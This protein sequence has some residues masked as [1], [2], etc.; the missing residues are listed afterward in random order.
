MLTQ[1]GMLAAPAGETP[2][3]SYTGIMEAASIIDNL[4]YTDI[5]TLD[6]YSKEAII[7][8]GALDVLKIPGSRQFRPQQAMTKQ[9]AIMMA[10]NAAG[11]EAEAQKAGEALNQARAQGNRKT[12]TIEVWADGYMQLALYD[13]LI[14]QQDYNNAISSGRTSTAQDTF[15]KNAA[16]TREEMAFWLA[17]A[18]KIEPV[19]GQQEIFN[20]YKDWK[21]SQPASVPYI[22]A[23]LAANIMYGSDGYFRPTGHV[24]REQGALIA[25]NAE[26]YILS[27]KNMVKK[28]GTIEDITSLKNYSSDSIDTGKVISIRNSDGSLHQIN[29]GLFQA[30]DANSAQISGTQ[31]IVVYRDGVAGSGSLLEKGDRIEYFVTS[32]NKTRFVNVVSNINST[33]YIAARITGMDE[34]LRKLS[35]TQFMQLDYPDIDLINSNTSLS[36]V[37]GSLQAVYSYSSIADVIEN[38]V[39]KDISSLGPDMTVILALNNSNI[40]T[41]IYISD[42]GENQDGYAIVSGIIEDVNPQLGYIAIYSNGKAYGQESNSKPVLKIYNYTNPNDLEIFRNHDI[43]SIEDLQ[44]G[45]TVFIKLDR[46]GEVVSASAADNYKSKYARVI[47]RNNS[48]LAVKYEDGTEQ[49]LN[50]GD[51]VAIIADGSPADISDIHD[52]DRIRLLVSSLGNSSKVIEITLEGD[53]H[54][55]SGIYKG[56]ITFVDAGLSQAAVANLEAYKD[57][58]WTRTTRKGITTVKIANGCEFYMGN[59]RL[60]MKR[61]GSKYKNAQAYIAV[62][63]DYGGKEQAVMISYRNTSDREVLYS[64]SVSYSIAGSG[65]FKIN[66]AGDSISYRN[67][68]IIIKNGRLV[69][70]SS[71]KDGDNAYVVANRDSDSGMFTAGIVQISDST[72]VNNFDIYRGRISAIS[73]NSGFT[74]E[75]F[76]RLSGLNWLYYNTP[77]TFEMTFNTRLLGDE[78]LIGQR[79]FV[80]YGDNSYKDRVVYVVAR[81]TEALLVSTA[82][83][84]S[85]NV[86]GQIYSLSGGMVGEEGTILEEPTEISIRNN[87][88][89]DMTQQLWTVAQDMTLTI[90]ANCVILKNGIE[91]KASE[92]EKGDIVR[93]IKKDSAAGGD[94]YIILVEGK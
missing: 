4:Q 47:S 68:S 86:R 50:I 22:E 15:N 31:D 3:A 29:T 69:T 41:A 30:P 33:K 58:K 17:K 20:S 34:S 83:Y 60:D 67:G 81:D 56:N 24:T 37:D 88:V 65:S 35:V 14:T 28:T 73:D 80:T 78:G 45:D 74:L 10:Y 7:E 54:L 40:V 8:A 79:D 36:P 1:P 49:I 92:L 76:S 89:F 91:I 53:E 21:A 44:P 94:A 48:R 43:A 87:T 26:A 6:A 25:K 64:D 11:R 63:K 90:P 12:D 46:D 51:D 71:I 59:T 16:V 52:G 72:A 23:I 19:Y 85:V 61:L 82:P 77:K 84:G 2:E 5:K 57:G 42:L 66:S 32:G 18:L 9:E 38:G 27:I 39:K 13:G 93:I 62:E 55:I 75:S 70:G